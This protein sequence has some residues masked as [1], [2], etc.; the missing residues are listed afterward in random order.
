MENSHIEFKNGFEN[1]F[2]NRVKFYEGLKR[3]VDVLG[4]FTGLL[5]LSPLIIIVSLIVKFTSQGPVFFSQGDEGLRLLHGLEP[6][7]ATSLQTP[8]E[9]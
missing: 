6:N 4:A 8:Q 3:L 5:M 1:E 2:E 9:A 7:L